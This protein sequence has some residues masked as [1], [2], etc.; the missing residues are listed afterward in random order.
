MKVTD[1][2][3]RQEY[4]PIIE[5]HN[6]DSNK[7]EISSSEQEN[8]LKEILRGKSI[9]D[10]PQKTQNFL[11]SYLASHTGSG[12]NQDDIIDS[13]TEVNDVINALKGYFAEQEKGLAEF[14][15]DSAPPNYITTPDADDKTFSQRAGDVV[16]SFAPSGVTIN[17]GISAGTADSET[18]AYA[19]ADVAVTG[20]LDN[21]ITGVVD[22]I[23]PLP[24]T[25][26]G[27]KAFVPALN[28]GAG[29]TSEDQKSGF[30][31]GSLPIDAS[32]PLGQNMPDLMKSYTKGD[33]ARVLSSNPEAAPVAVA[34]YTL[35]D[36]Q[37]QDH[38]YFQIFGGSSPSG[39]NE[40][41]TVW[42]DLVQG[43][44]R[45]GASVEARFTNGLRIG[46]GYVFEAY[47]AVGSD[48]D[49][50]NEIKKNDFELHAVYE[51]DLT[52]KHSLLAGL[53]FG[54]SVSTQSQATSEGLVTRDLDVNDPFFDLSNPNIT[55]DVAGN[56]LMTVP[57]VE[58]G[59]GSGDLKISIPLG[60][61]W[62]GKNLVAPGGK[63]I[64]F[65]AGVSLRID[66]V[67]TEEYAEEKRGIDPATSNPTGEILKGGGETEVYTDVQAVAGAAIDLSKRQD[68]SFTAAAEGGLTYNNV[69]HSKNNGLGG[70]FRLVLRWFFPI[71]KSKK[72]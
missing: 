4:R 62:D 71:R 41:L 65:H 43:N 7:E 25:S 59:E 49:Q 57:G 1:S 44:L 6:T 66:I 50:P 72:N 21:G 28:W 26:D 61:R 35:K 51:H 24:I 29:W 20:R 8:A 27:L 56:P 17:P 47:K 9:S 15:Y 69:P 13:E 10:L 58:V 31:I 45:A 22:V 64:S 5:K 37:G 40:D 12:H 36:D 30:M 67:K 38:V 33:V 53:G 3:I 46:G 54:M 18:G 39:H 48:P 42:E 68:R 11:R 34:W 19:E 70:F 55:Y 16:K 2:G 23:A 63:N 14:F 60:L 32:D 52:E